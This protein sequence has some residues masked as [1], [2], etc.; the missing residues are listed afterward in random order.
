[1]TVVPPTPL[2]FLTAWPAGAAQPL[3]STLN[4]LKGLPL[5]NAALVPAG[6]AGGINVYVSSSSHVVIDANGYFQ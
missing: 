2:G 1:M 4:D 3:A 6:A 5:A